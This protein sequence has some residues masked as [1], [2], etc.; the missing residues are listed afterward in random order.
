MLAVGADLHP[1]LRAQELGIPVYSYPSYFHQQTK[2]K[3]RVVIGGSHGKTTIT[4]LLESIFVAAGWT[5]GLGTA[6]SRIPA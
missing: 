1:R 4:Y 2:D 5:A 3:T 6:Q